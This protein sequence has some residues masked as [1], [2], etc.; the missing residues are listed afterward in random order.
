[1][2]IQEIRAELAAHADPKNAEFFKKLNPTAKPCIGVRIPIMRKLAQR[3]A[4]EDYRG[5][6]DH[7]PMDTYELESLHAF[8][9][10][11]AKDDIRVLLSY[12]DTFIPTI[13]DWSVSDS[14]CQTFKIARKYPDETFDLLMKYRD[15]HREFEVRVVAVMLMSQFLTDKYIDRVIEVIN[16]LYIE[17]FYAKMG[18][19][20]AVATIMAKYPDKCLAY[21]LSP[22]NKLD[23]WTYNKALQKMKESY[24]V[25]NAMV[26]KIKGAG[27][28]K[29]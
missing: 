3:I 14:L 16:S 2:D 13:H 21:M 24:R 15:S 10:G 7:N 27:R 26:E 23:E 22:D 28:T 17:D 19:A 9:I 8:V 1:M 5:F 18:V 20:W 11:Y 12:L 6:L 29:R 4:K 25:D